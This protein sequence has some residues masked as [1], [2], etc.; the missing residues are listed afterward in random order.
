MSPHRQLI[1][2]RHDA[3]L[4]RNTSR[5]VETDERLNILVIADVHANLVAL[6]AVL[7]DC[8]SVDGLW[9]LGDS[10]GYGPRP[11]QCLTLLRGSNPLMTLAGNHDLAAIGAL[12]LAAFNPTAQAAA[13]WTA[14]NLTEPQ[15]AHLASLPAMTTDQG[16]TLVHGS[17]R[18]PIWEYVTDSRT[19]A[20][21]LRD[22]ETDVCFVG[23]SHVAMYATLQAHQ[24]RPELFSLAYGQTLELGSAR[25]LINPGSVGQPRDRDPRAAYAILDTERGTLTGHRVD[26]DIVATQRQIYE[27]KLPALLAERLADGV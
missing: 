9:N 25:F 17:P 2:A 5:S 4:R 13:R 18:D 21:A 23:H 19:A 26:Y 15:R 27:A 11:G 14:R 10:V 24:T 1:T 3:I 6:E 22:I 8:P 7:R 12:S 16:F 20:A